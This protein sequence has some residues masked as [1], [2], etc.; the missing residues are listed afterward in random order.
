[1]KSQEAPESSKRRS[2][3]LPFIP[4]RK[5][6][7][8]VETLHKKLACEAVPLPRAV[9]VLGFDALSGRAYR[10]LAALKAYGLVS[11]ENDKGV[12]I[13]VTEVGA[14]LVEKAKGENLKVLRLA[15][16][17]PRPFRRFWFKRPG[18]SE[19]GLSN[20]LLK[21]N[22]TETGAKRA[23]R[24]YLANVRF[25]QLEDADFRESGEVAVPAEWEKASAGGAGELASV[26]PVTNNITKEQASKQRLRIPLG[27]DF[28]TV[29]LALKKED[30]YTLMQTLKLWRSQIVTN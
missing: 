7:G 20:L 11:R 30:F 16:L 8:Y 21:R 3:R 27:D 18:I 2:P 9:R 29:P 15:A 19:Q 14:K 23:A 10:V 22:F 26:E 25:A 28:A 12:K 4:L 1:M 13:R 5:A 24:V 6:L 17:E